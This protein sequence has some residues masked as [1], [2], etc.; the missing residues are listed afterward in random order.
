MAHIETQ[1]SASSL[2]FQETDLYRSVLSRNSTG[3]IV[4][5]VYTIFF[6]EFNYS[7]V[8]VSNE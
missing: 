6:N 5:A 7:C 2:W 8:N 1:L 3:F 4:I